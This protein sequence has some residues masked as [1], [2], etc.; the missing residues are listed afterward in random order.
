VQFDSRFF[1]FEPYQST[2]PLPIYGGFGLGLNKGQEVTFG[3]GLI[4]VHGDA[5]GGGGTLS[6]N[7]LRWRRQIAEKKDKGEVYLGAGGGFDIVWLEFFKR[8]YGYRVMAQAAL[9]MHSRIGL[10]VALPVSLTYTDLR[11]KGGRGFSFTPGISIGVEH[12]D[13]SLRLGG[14]FPLGNFFQ[15]R[16][17]VGDTTY[18]R[19]MTSYLGLRLALKFPLLK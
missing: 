8:Y 2:L 5:C 7:E 1:T 16:F 9:G 14:D 15:D 19:G 6:A 12:D 10:G 13:F 11:V 17:R 18:L 3:W 4:G